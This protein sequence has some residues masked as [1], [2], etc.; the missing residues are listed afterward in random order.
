[1][2]R[3]ITLVASLCV[4]LAAS[5]GYSSTIKSPTYD[6]SP[7]NV[8]IDNGSVV[9]NTGKSPYSSLVKIKV[10]GHLCTGTLIQY[11]K[12]LTAGECT[13]DESGKV[14]AAG[15][16]TV[17]SSDGKKSWHVKEI[18]A[19]STLDPASDF[20]VLKIDNTDKN[21]PTVPL[22]SKQVTQHW[23]LTKY[24]S[25]LTVGYGVDL[26][27]PDKN[28]KADLQQGT[29]TPTSQSNAQKTVKQGFAWLSSKGVTITGKYDGKGV[30][31][32]CSKQAINYGD[33]GGPVFYQNPADH[34]FYL[35]GTTSGGL[36]FPDSK[37][38]GKYLSYDRCIDH[39]G[40]DQKGQKISIFTD[41][42]YGSFNYK[43]LKTIEGQ[44][45]KS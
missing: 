13:Q 32:T 21:T 45:S 23:L 16:F 17:T 40:V 30:F 9:K 35:I 33:A 27:R 41:L 14:I 43:K 22:S 26:A 19:A 15:L 37:V 3:Y 2:S 34:S 25:L 10:N 11:N 28:N 18:K 4:T 8:F 31:S 38:K 20:A 7:F 1:M 12:I 44:M 36:T 5:T 24:P 39:N 42:T 29:V 6:T